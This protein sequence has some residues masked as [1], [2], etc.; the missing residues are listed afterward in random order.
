MEWS[1][2]EQNG[3][4]WNGMGMAVQSGLVLFRWPCTLAQI[5]ASDGP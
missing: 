3:F 2:V 4:G 5:D 1:G